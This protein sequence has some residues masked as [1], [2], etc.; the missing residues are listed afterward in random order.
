VGQYYWTVFV[1]ENVTGT[2]NHAWKCQN[3]WASLNFSGS[4]NVFV[5]AIDKSATFN[6]TLMNNPDLQGY[7]RNYDSATNV[8]NDLYS[9][10]CFLGVFAI[11]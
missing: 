7:V 4:Y 6:T 3:C 8:A 5:A 9:Q 10:Y 1:Y 2:A 11:K